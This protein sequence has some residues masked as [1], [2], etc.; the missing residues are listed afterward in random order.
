MATR[1]S[2]PTSTSRTTVRTATTRT[3]HASTATT[4]TTRTTAA[5]TT[6]A[7]TWT[8]TTDLAQPHHLGRLRTRSPPGAEPAELVSWPHGFARLA[9]F[10]AAQTGCS[11]HRR[12]S[13]CASP[14]GSVPELA[15]R[16]V[17]EV[18]VRARSSAGGRLDGRRETGGRSTTAAQAQ[19]R[20]HRPNPTPHEP[21]GGHTGTTHRRHR[22][23]AGRTG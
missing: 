18:T 7:T 20:P 9:G 5:T 22:P 11:S 19:P 2:T 10:P 17:R 3:T 16:R 1:T 13:V 8:S 23:Y 12:C 6:T 14:T 15:V 21:N 4:T